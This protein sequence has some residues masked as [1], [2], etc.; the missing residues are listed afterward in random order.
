MSR[1]SKIAAF[2]GIITLIVVA[3]FVVRRTGAQSAATA[4]ATARAA[5]ATEQEWIVREIVRYIAA[6]AAAARTGTDSPAPEV[7]VRT[8]PGSQLDL[9]NAATLDVEVGTAPAV[10]VPVRDHVWSPRTYVG[11]AAALLPAG[12]KPRPVGESSSAASASS[13]ILQTL[14]DPR[15]A[16]ILAEE[17]RVT[18]AIKAQPLNA[19]LREDA[20][21][22]TVVMAL[23]ERAGS[24]AD[25][26]PLLNRTAAHLA[27]AA[28]LRGERPP[29]PSGRAAAIAVDVLVGREDLAMP[30]IDAWA[31]SDTA[32]ATATWLRALRLRATGD[33]RQASITSASPLLERLEYARALRDRVGCNR[34]VALLDAHPEFEH[35]ADWQRIVLEN[36]WLSFTVEAGH[37]FASSGLDIEL[38]ELAEAWRHYHR[39]DPAQDV[40]IASLD[41]P[42]PTTYRAIDWSAWAGFLERHLCAQLS[43]A[44]RHIGNLGYYAEEDEGWLNTAKPFR[45]LRLFPFVPLSW[46]QN[47]ERYVQAYAPAS[48]VF[49]SVPELR[50]ANLAEMLQTPTRLARNP[51]VRPWSDVAWFT[52]HV[53]T[54]TAFELAF[55]TLAAGCRRPVPPPQVARWAS[56]APH[57]FWVPYSLVFVRSDANPTIAE[58]SRALPHLLDYDIRVLERLFL[59]LDGNSEE[60]LSVARKMCGLDTSECPKLGNELLWNGREKEAADVYETFARTARDSVAVS[61]DTDWL[62]R[63]WWD[64]GRRDR[65]LALA[66][67][68]ADVGSSTGLRTYGFLLMILGRDDEALELFEEDARHYRWKGHVATFYLHKARETGDQAWVQRASATVPDIFPNGIER[69]DDAWLPVPPPDGVMF[70]SF[71]PRAARTGLQ[72]D[73]I[74][75]G[76]E[77]YRVHTVEQYNVVMYSSFD[78]HVR[79][80]VWRNGRHQTIQAD[81]PQRRAGVNLATYP[82]SAKRRIWKK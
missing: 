38:E 58:V 29:G 80:R 66:K 56:Q 46:V 75:V 11:L 35:V 1:T 62:V 52:P 3:G 79:M 36:D 16:V 12:A 7:F 69:V 30:Q 61:N 20:A 17:A 42:A 27:L 2:L 18:A 48:S 26:R 47:G 64:T 22:L 34:V 23:R 67:E 25:H 78:P 73:D 59:Y 63:Y 19:G 10:S 65:A 43:A 14:T 4:N 41:E 68:S 60:Y 72:P 28:A 50:S 74:V 40:L 24:Y 44:G 57:D 53:P 15:V 32:T 31:R 8:R 5:F 51:S 21:L 9:L 13:P 49:A 39:G 54:G 37:R 82:S 77:G 76:V 81:I 71:G 45:R 33:W 70:T 6:G 55:R